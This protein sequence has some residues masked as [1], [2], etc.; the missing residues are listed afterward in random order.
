M[1]EASSSDN[2]K[3]WGVVQ[4]SMKNRLNF[5]VKDFRMNSMA[6]IKLCVDLFGV[7]RALFS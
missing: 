7:I 5:M 4:S 3:A 6:G 2:S 1:M